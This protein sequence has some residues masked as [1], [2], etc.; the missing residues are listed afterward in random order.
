MKSSVVRQ[1]ERK[2]QSKKKRD[3]DREGEYTVPADESFV[4]FWRMA[5]SHT[6]GSVYLTLSERQ[7]CITFL[8]VML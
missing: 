2:K 5:Q 3:S 1:R 8:V 6:L 7:R 4:T